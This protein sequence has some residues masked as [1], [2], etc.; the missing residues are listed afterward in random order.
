MGSKTEDMR[1][2]SKGSRRASRVASLE[3]SILNRYSARNA[4]VLTNSDVLGFPFLKAIDAA[5]VLFLICYSLHILYLF[6][7]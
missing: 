5:V 7:V 6:E 2:S 4:L 3:D 1:R